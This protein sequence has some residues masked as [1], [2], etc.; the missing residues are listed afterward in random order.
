LIYAGDPTEATGHF[1]AAYRERPTSVSTARWWA[2]SL[3]IF[4]QTE[5]A[6]QVL[7]VVET[8][9]PTDPTIRLYQA[10]F[11][12]LAGDYA[13]AVEAAD[14]S[15]AINNVW[16][17]RMQKGKALIMLD[18]LDEAV[19]EL[20]AAVA[21]QETMQAPKAYLGYAYGLQGRDRDARSMRASARFV[22][23][24]D[25]SRTQ[26]EALQ[27]VISIG[28]NQIDR[29]KRELIAAREAADPAL[30]LLINDPILSPAYD[31]VAE[32]LP[33]ETVTLLDTP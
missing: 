14:R 29:A 22:P 30:W 12:Y 17:G 15:I 16:I 13:G 21:E 4:G 2:L 24:D 33:A 18:R 8:Y 23:S 32:M 6:L 19:R 5:E 7:D 20:E 3:A 10:T 1:A 25:P 28:L 11:R 27:A 31:T 26:S 9:S